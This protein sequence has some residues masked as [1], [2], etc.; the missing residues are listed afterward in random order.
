[1]MNKIIFRDILIH[2]F[3]TFKSPIKIV[4]F[5]LVFLCFAISAQSFDWPMD[6]EGIGRT[7][8]SPEALYFPLKTL[9]SSPIYCENKI[10]K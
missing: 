4:S 5:L 8:N 6:R 3:N 9:F 1:M 7:A 10:K 2:F